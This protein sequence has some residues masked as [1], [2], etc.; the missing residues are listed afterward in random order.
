MKDRK[1][2]RW[3]LI[4]S[5]ASSPGDNPFALAID[6]YRETFFV[7]ARRQE[8]GLH[9]VIDAP[10]SGGRISGHN[11]PRDTGMPVSLDR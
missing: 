4:Q 10:C 3:A 11:G 5:R 9:G 6:P 7:R 8:K 2:P 1:R